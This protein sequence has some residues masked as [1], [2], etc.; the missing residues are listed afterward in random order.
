MATVMGTTKAIV[1]L[2]TEPGNEH[3]VVETLGPNTRVEALSSQSGWLKV[4]YQGKTGFV[5]AYFINLDAPLPPEPQT[6]TPPSPPAKTLDPNAISLEPPA[7]QKI[8]VPSTA[9]YLERLAAEVWNK[10]GG[11]LSALSAQLQIDPGV[12]IAVFAIESGGRG[13]ETDGRLLIRFENHIFYEYWGKNNKTKFNQHFRFS[14]T[15]TWTGHQFRRSN[16]QGWQDVHIRQQ[17]REW[18]AFEFANQ[19]SSTAAKLSISMGAPQIMGFNYELLGF[20]SVHEMF[21][22]FT[23]GDREQ[24]LAFFEFVKGKDNRKV[25]ALQKKDYNTFAKYYNGSGQAQKYGGLIQD[26]YEIYAHLKK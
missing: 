8:N 20:R 24:I 14:P 18:E 9:P 25:D 4:R 1:R 26:V 13:F 3:P 2:R 11:I 21:D 6:G 12:A 22:A 5:N 23:K 19:L 7:G 15:Q 17:S 16:S 10:Y